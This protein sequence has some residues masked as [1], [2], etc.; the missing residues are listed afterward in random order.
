MKRTAATLV[1]LAGLGGSG[2]TTPQSQSQNAQP[3]GGFGTVTRG[4][5]VDTVQGPLGE[6]VMASRGQMPAGTG[7]RQAGDRG[8]L[9]GGT[10][11]VIRPA[12]GVTPSTATTADGYVTAMVPGVGGSL[13]RTSGYDFGPPPSGYGASGPY[14]PQQPQ[15]FPKHGIV[16]VPTQGPPG[17]VAAVGA[18]TAGA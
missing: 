11:A 4:K 14:G 10:G 15:N 7:V 12:G 18:Y 13:V 17:A 3:A 8:T 9:F 2:C 5:Q 6:P 1:L 16:P